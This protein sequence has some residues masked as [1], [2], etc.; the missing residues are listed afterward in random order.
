GPYHRLKARE[1]GLWALSSTLPLT[2]YPDRRPLI[3]GASLA[4]N[5]IGANGAIAAL[6]ALYAR[7]ELGAGQQVEVSGH[8]VLIY[9][10]GVMLSQI[11]DQAQRQRTGVRALGAAPWAFFQCRDRMI[12]LLALFP[13]HWKILADWIFEETGNEAALDPKYQG[14]PMVRGRHV[15]EV[16][17]L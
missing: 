6:A 17:A 11:D 2:G 3:P 16:E 1:L 5:L 14:G 8:E 15:E 4:N 13:N 12:S 10:G 9:S 7:Q